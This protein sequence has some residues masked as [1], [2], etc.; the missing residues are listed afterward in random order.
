MTTKYVLLTAFFVLTGFII[1]PEYKAYYTHS[2]HE[3][4][5]ERA[6]IEAEKIKIIGAALKGNESYIEYEKAL[7]SPN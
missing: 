3:S 4:E 1:A 7:S 5:I 6:E 2:M